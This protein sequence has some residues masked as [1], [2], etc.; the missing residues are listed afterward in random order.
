MQMVEFSAEGGS[1]V[2]KEG[3]EGVECGKGEFNAEGGGSSVQKGGLSVEG[4]S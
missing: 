3:G 1:R 4:G 2:W